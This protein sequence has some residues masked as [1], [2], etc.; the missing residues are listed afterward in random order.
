M[1]GEAAYHQ[2][3]D[4]RRSRRSRRH[5][6]DIYEQRGRS[7]PSSMA[8][9]APVPAIGT[10]IAGGTANFMEGPSAPPTY[11]FPFISPQVCSTMNYGQFT[12]LM[13]RP[14]YWFGNNNTPTVDPNYSIGNPPT[15]S[16]GDKTVTVTLKHWMWSDGE[17]VTSRDVEFWMN[18][19]FAEKD[20]WCDYT[21]GYFP[22]NVVSISLPELHDGRVP[23]EAG[24]QPDLVPL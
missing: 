24:L 23:H 20:N 1:A 19:M 2:D 21:P 9:P 8:R 22:D 14:L 10:K 13:Y 6:C 11:I 18:L 17:Q 12:Y 5:G 3:P 16:N 4:A 15:F 7:W